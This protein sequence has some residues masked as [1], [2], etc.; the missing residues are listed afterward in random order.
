[1]SIIIKS[2]FFLMAA[3]MGTVFASLG[4][5]FIVIFLLEKIYRT[6]KENE[7]PK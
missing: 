6:K 3:G 7:V 5:F 1:M 2:G 4:I